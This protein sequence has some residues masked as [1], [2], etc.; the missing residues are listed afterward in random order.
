M[1]RFLVSVENKATE[2]EREKLKDKFVEFLRENGFPTVN[3]DPDE[4]ENLIS[5]L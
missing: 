2:T 4:D 5:S 3:G 1:F